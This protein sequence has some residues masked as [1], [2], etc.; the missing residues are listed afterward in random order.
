[1]AAYASR[2]KSLRTPASSTLA[3]LSAQKALVVVDVGADDDESIDYV[4]HLRWPVAAEQ[5]GITP[6]SASSTNTAIA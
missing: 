2:R 5:S 1:M 6:D 4:R 3:V